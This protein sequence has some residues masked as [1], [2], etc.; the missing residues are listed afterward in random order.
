M[1]FMPTGGISVQNA[2]DYLS[3]PSVAAV[4]GSWMVPA[5]LIGAH[6]W[7]AVTELARAAAALAEVR[8]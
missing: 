3:I 5:G 8:A 7:A 1:T 6:D 4:G 2:G